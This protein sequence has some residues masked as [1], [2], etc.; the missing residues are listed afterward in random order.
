MVSMLTIDCDFPGGNILLD[1]VEGD[2]VYL[3]ADMRDTE[4]EWFYWAFRLRNGAGRR[5][6]FHFAPQKPVGM[7]GAALSQD[8]GLSWRWQE[9]AFTVDGFVLD[10]P[11]AAPEILVAVSFVYT[12]A[13]WDQFLATL[14]PSAAWSTGV[15][16][17]TRKGRNVEIL[18]LGA[19]DGVAERRVIF[20]ARHHCCEMIASFTMEG[21]ITEILGGVGAA[22]WL[23]ERVRFLF[24]PFVD[25]DGV[26]DG[27]QG[28]NRRPRDHNRDYIGSSV[29]V[30]TAAIR[31]LLQPWAD[32][33]GIDAAIDL[34]CPGLRGSGHDVVFQVGREDPK[35]WAEQV[36]FGERL[37]AVCSPAGLPYLTA[38]NL[39]FGQGWNCAANSKGGMGFSRW[40]AGLPGVRLATTL[41]IPYASAGGVEVSAER[42]RQLGRDIAAALAD[43]LRT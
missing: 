21:I 35:C 8:G 23:R 36:R 5:L 32:A 12:Q 24:I 33:H 4:G 27:D 16:C 7:K 30:E 9:G 37:E 28:K 11:A 40:A 2:D 18:R 43:Y 20:T 17:R 29:H 25:K 13:H 3:H 38:N 15:L 14:P 42:A 41:E 19:P 6:R 39:P 10:V 22:A 34:H 31:K 26:E 1:R